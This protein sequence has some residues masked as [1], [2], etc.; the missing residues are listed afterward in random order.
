MGG[1]NPVHREV[2]VAKTI[3]EARQS[4]MATLQM[5]RGKVATFGD[6]SI[7]CDFGS[8]LKSRLIGEF[9]VSKATLPK[10][11]TITL[12]QAE[13]GATAITVDVR[14]THKYGVKW[15]YETKYEQALG[16]LADSILNGIKSWG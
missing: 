3:S 14:D 12:K 16:E 9:W 10:R 11:A 4:I 7:E 1:I 6:S 8:L 13:S 5:L 2:T 15:G